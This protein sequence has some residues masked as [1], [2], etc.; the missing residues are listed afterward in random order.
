M[1]IVLAA[2]T[3]FASLFSSWFA[4]ALLNIKLTLRNSQLQCSKPLHA[5]ALSVTKLRC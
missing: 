5:R 3:D 2:S 4:R 1:G